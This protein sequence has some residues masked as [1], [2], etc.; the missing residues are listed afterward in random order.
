MNL[1][2]YREILAA[3]VQKPFDY[4][5]QKIANELII[6]N[7]ATLI[8]QQYEKTSIFPN[9]AVVQT[10][11]PVELVNSVDCCSVDLGCKI[12]SSSVL[13]VPIDVKD[14]RLFDYVGGLDWANAFTYVN[15]YE[16]QFIKNRKYSSHKIFYTWLNKRLS[17][18]SIHPE[19]LKGIEKIGIRYVPYNPLDLASLRCADAPCY[20][21]ED[22][23]FIE[24]HWEDTLTKMILPKLK[25]ILGEQIEVKENTNGK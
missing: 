19:M 5:I 10:C 11:I 4:A 9:S 6:A 12:L 24:G 2:I 8:R 20:D 14:K 7:R 13:P 22:E 21:V 18:Y 1:A 15:P 3:E 16:V 25:A 23:T 17:F